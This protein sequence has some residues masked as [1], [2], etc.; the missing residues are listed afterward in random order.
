MSEKPVGRPFPPGKSGNPGGRP[1]ALINISAAAKKYS[2]EALDLLVSAVRCE[3]A[4]WST[5]VAAACQLLDRAFG[6]PMQSIAL[7]SLEGRTMTDAELLAIAAGA[8]EGEILDLNAEVIDQ[9]G[10]KLN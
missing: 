9:N 2:Q 10:E 4:G 7:Q 1:K 8:D 3:Q 6:K 5:R